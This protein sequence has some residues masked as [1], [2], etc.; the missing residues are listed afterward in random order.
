MSS[1]IPS[2]DTD[3]GWKHC[4]FEPA[5]WE[6]LA[7]CIR[8]KLRPF[9]PDKSAE[10]DPTF[11]HPADAW[12]NSLL[13]VSYSGVSLMLSLRRRLT[14]AELRAERDDL[15]RTLNK[16][17][18]SLGTVSHDLDILFGINADVLGTRDKLKALIPFITD[19]GSRIAGLPRAKKLMDA[20][21]DAAVEMAIRA[22]RVLKGHGGTTTATANRDLEYVSDA[23]KILKIVGDELGLKLD[24]TTWKKVMAEAKTAAPDLR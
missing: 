24:E 21:H 18:S 2:Y 8:E 15:L 5:D 12:A 19:S 20:N 9:Y 1:A 6:A 16:A 11:G 3:A 22:L 4:I 17:V 10:E 7:K 13:D 14:K 23:I